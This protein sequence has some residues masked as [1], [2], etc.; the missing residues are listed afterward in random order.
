MLTRKGEPAAA[1]S[2]RIERLAPRLE[3]NNGEAV[4]AALVELL[5]EAREPV[6]EHEDE[7]GQYEDAALEVVAL[8][9]V[10]ISNWPA[11]AVFDWIAG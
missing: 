7:V 1:P 3:T 2:D 4:G 10:M 5:R 9:E 6:A 8:R 11:R